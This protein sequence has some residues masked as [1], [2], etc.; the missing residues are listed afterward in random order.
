MQ[1][2]FEGLLNVGLIKPQQRFEMK[3][4]SKCNELL[5]TLMTVG[6]LFALDKNVDV[7]AVEYPPFTGRSEPEGG[8]AFQLLNDLTVDEQ[9]NW[10]PFFL[11]PKR[12]YNKIELGDWCASFYPVFSK[13]DFKQY[14]L[15]KGLVKIGLVRLSKLTPFMWSS[16]DDLQVKNVAL[17]STESRSELAMQFENSGVKV[18]NIETI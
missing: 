15:G 2:T 7:I 3:H 6:S 5:L 17:L 18:V 11:P 1:Q 9:I 10:K 14:E 8:L 12:A 4:L 13:T 16:I